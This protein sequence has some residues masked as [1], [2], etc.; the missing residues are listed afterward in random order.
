MTASVLPFA[1]ILRSARGFAGFAPPASPSNSPFEPL[2]IWCT[3]RCEYHQR[4]SHIRRVLIVESVASDLATEVASLREIG[5]WTVVV[6]STPD[7][8]IKAAKREKVDVVLL[9]CGAPDPAIVE[10]AKRLRA[11]P[12]TMDLPI[13][14]LAEGAS[15]DLS[16]FA[17]DAGALGTLRKPLDTLEL[18]VQIRDLVGADAGAGPDVLFRGK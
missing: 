7:E 4:V 10:L 5:R 9:G 12:A 6:A 8:I 3:A 14:L 2:K 15:R 16:A 1:Q 11:D 13:I 17:R 18:P